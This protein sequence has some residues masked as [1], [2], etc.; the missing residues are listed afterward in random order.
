MEKVGRLIMRVQ[1]SFKGFVARRNYKSK[2]KENVFN[3]VINTLLIG[4]KKVFHYI[5]I[6]GN[7]QLNKSL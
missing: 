6:L 7:D 3:I 5:R 4:K 1:A 2:I